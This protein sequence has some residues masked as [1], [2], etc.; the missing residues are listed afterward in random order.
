MFEIESVMSADRNL[1][2]DEYRGEI[3][4][5]DCGNAKDDYENPAPSSF[6]KS[7]QQEMN[8]SEHVQHIW[9]PIVGDSDSRGRPALAYSTTPKEEIKSR[10]RLLQTIV[11]DCER[12]L[13]KVETLY[14][15]IAELEE[16]DSHSPEIENQRRALGCGSRLRGF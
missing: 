11:K 6:T 2:K 13:T 12:T 1:T 4:C 9:P 16:E 8:R 5:E 7:P 14:N 3:H 15:M 10:K